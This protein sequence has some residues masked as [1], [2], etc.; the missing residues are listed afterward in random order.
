[1]RFGFG[2]IGKDGPE[3]RGLSER[4]VASDNGPPFA[5]GFDNNYLQIFQG[6][7]HVVILNEQIHDARTVSSTSGRRSTQSCAVGTA[8]RA[9]TG[10]AT[11]W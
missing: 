4:C 3:D 5:P 9:G 8:T 6:R 10:K 2:G 1:M 7:D 11:R